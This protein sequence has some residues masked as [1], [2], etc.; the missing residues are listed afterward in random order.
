MSINWRK[1]LRADSF[2]CEYLVEDYLQDKSVHLEVE[3]VKWIGSFFVLFLSP[4][5]DNL[6]NFA[7]PEPHR[8]S[9]QPT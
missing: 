7:G 3:H 8:V 5:L 6:I 2:Q 4:H 9:R 1:Y